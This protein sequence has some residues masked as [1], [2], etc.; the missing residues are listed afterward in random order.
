[1][2]YIK[3]EKFCVSASFAFGENT[4]LHPNGKEFKEIIKIIECSVRDIKQT[5][6]ARHV[7]LE[8]WLLLD[9]II[10]HFII[11]GL[12]LNKFS[13]INFN[14]ADLLPTSFETC[15]KFL[16][17]FIKN[18][19]EMSPNPE[20]NKVDFYGKFAIFI[21]QEQKDFYDKQFIPILRKYYKKYYPELVDTAKTFTARE[22]EKERR[23]YALN[24][25]S[26]QN[27]IVDETNI[28]TYREVDDVWFKLANRLETGWFNNVKKI[29][30]AR[31]ISAHN[32]KSES[33]Y[34]AIGI[35]G[36]DEEDKFKKTKNFCI[37]QLSEILDIHIR[38]KEQQEV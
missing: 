12:N 20:K 2:Q 35:N 11:S 15:L 18:Q 36:K 27:D 4:P 29:N 28:K 1:M 32:I 8:T 16:E 13:N 33:I 19:K 38:Q 24:V 14:I 10:R 22:R 37:Q 30:K 34:K 9:Y 3:K 26:Q 31:N 23:I 6:S 17:K 21:I 5:K 7:I 25:I